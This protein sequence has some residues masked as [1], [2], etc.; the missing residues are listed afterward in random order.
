[1]WWLMH[2][3][4]SVAS[5]HIDRYGHLTS[6]GEIFDEDHLP[7]GVKTGDR[8]HT[9]EGLDRWWSKR[10]IPI[11]RPGVSAML[12]SMGIASTESLQMMSK[13]LGLSDS[14][15]IRPEGSDLS[16]SDVNFHDNDFSEEVGN[17]LFNHGT[18]DVLNFDSPDSSSDGNLRK[19]WVIEDGVRILMKGG[20]GQMQEPFNEVLASEI[21]RRLD[22]RHVDYNLRWVDGEPFSVCPAFTDSRTELVPAWSVLATCKREDGET[23]YDFTRRCFECCG[24]KDPTASLERMIAVDFLI[25]NEDRHLGN[26]G[27]LRDPETL[28]TKGFAPLYDN[29]ASLGH[30][31]ITL[32][33]EEGYD[34]ICRPFKVTHGEQIHLVRDLGWFDPDRL[35]G[36]DDF[37]KDLFDGSKGFV[38]ERR[39]KA[40]IGF[41]QRRIDKLAQYAESPDFRDDRHLDLRV[42]SG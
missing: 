37:A 8:E 38:D 15:W 30:R 34:L 3:D 11:S 23:L 24:L 20:S 12:E 36:M 9:L 18:T 29:G 28:K 42:V 19:R 13:G 14:Y 31:V 7:V 4:I 33:I 1:M 35:E 41:L 5:V 6:L 32:W 16:W 27:L 40:I 39:N 10:A 26:F 21:M 22:V 2:G 17:A 25:A